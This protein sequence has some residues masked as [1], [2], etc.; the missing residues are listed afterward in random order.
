MIEP[1]ASI[2]FSLDPGTVV[3]IVAICGSIIASA[4]GAY[5]SIKGLIKS[6]TNRLCEK[7]AEATA[8]MSNI[9]SSVKKFEP[10][11]KEVHSHISS[12]EKTVDSHF[13]DITTALGTMNRDNGI[14]IGIASKANG[15]SK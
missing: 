6:S 12:T 8:S 4:I 1:A 14:L 15:V 5:Y 10:M 7:I 11:I 2:P 13:S 3:E 9:D